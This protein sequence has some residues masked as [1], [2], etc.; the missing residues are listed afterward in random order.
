MKFARFFVTSV[1]LL[2][3]AFMVACNA[4]YRRDKHPVDELVKEGNEKLKESRAIQDDL[5]SKYDL[6]VDADARN[7][8][9]TPANFPFK[10]LSKAQRREIQSKLAQFLALI[11]RVLEIDTTKNIT[12]E[13]RETILSSRDLAED[14]QKRLEIFEQIYGENFNPKLDSHGSPIRSASR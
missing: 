3:I 8:K 6:V 13:N 14:F 2:G 7:S 10:K 11:N 5:S 9:P 1:M 4:S 12:I